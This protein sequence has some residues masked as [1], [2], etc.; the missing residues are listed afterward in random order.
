MKIAERY[1]AVIGEAQ[2][3]LVHDRTG[4]PGEALLALNRALHE[5]HEWRRECD[6]RITEHNARVKARMMRSVPPSERDSVKVE[7]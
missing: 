3:A 6:Q 5:L 4:D 2:R 1:T 7:R